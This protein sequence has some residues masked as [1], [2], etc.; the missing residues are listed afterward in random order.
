[1]LWKYQVWFKA[2]ILQLLLVFFVTLLK[3]HSGVLFPRNTLV[4]WALAFLSVSTRE[5][6]RPANLVPRSN[7]QVQEAH[8]KCEVKTHSVQLLSHR[9]ADKLSATNRWGIYSQRLFLFFPFFLKV[10][11][12]SGAL[13]TEPL[14]IIPPG[15]AVLRPLR[16]YLTNT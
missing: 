13:S 3:A 11:V 7:L 6:L 12:N 10:Q 5:V 9:H 1:M 16:A 2:D 4:P 15:E 14:S 8:Q